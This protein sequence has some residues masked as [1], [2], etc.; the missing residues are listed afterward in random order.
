MRARLLDMGEV[1]AVR[2]QSLVR[3][4][5]EGFEASSV[6]VVILVK[7]C[8]PIVAVG[9]DAEP[10]ATRVD[11]ELCRGERIPV[12][13]MSGVDG[14]R[15]LYPNHLLVS[16][17]LLREQAAELKLLEAGE[18][19]LAAAGP[20]L[21]VSERFSIAAVIDDRGRLQVSGRDLGR[22]A[23]LTLPAAVGILWDLRIN[24]D[25]G[26]ADLEARALAPAYAADPASFPT[27]RTGFQVEAAGDV[28]FAEIGE[29]LVAAVE[30]RLG[31]ELV[32]SMP[33][34]AELDALYEWD[35][36]LLLE[37]PPA[38]G[39]RTDSGPTTYIM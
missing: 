19:P 5:A 31:L 37:E 30:S 10:P 28:T 34:P 23:P 2:S 35:Q 26:E 14:A 22:F 11:L 21:E 16:L 25:A 4:V 1:G 12:V 18:W 7:P 17:V 38:D 36:R 32:P 6:P 13:R 24:P 3:A 33:T 15:L 8:E 20:L 39:G 9:D 29:A 27:D